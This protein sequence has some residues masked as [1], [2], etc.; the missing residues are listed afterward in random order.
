MIEAIMYFCIGFLSAALVG[1][2]IAPLIHGRAV[3]LTR[4]RLENALPQSM[5]EIIADKDLQRADFAVATRR[6]EM[7]IE[8]LKESNTSQ[9]AEIGRKDNIINRFKVD[10]QTHQV[11]TLLLR[12]EVASLREQL[13]PAAI[14]PDIEQRRTNEV[15]V[16]MRA[17]PTE[18]PGSDAACVIAS[19]A[20][21]AEP[22]PVGPITTKETVSKHEGNHSDAS[23]VPAQPPV[24]VAGDS[25][26]GPAMPE[27]VPERGIASMSRP[28]PSIHVS[29]ADHFALERTGRRTWLP[30]FGLVVVLVI[31]GSGWS[32]YRGADLPIASWKQAIIS[33][34]PKTTK[35]TPPPVEKASAPAPVEQIEDLS[36]RAPDL[37]SGVEQPSSMQ[38]DAPNKNPDLV[39]SEPPKEAL[40]SPAP[41]P[42]PKL[43]PVPETPPTTIPGWVVREVTDGT[44]VV[45]GPNGI[46]K[47]GRGDVLPGAGR[48][49]SI[50]R[51]GRRWIVATNRGLISTP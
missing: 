33:M 8:K 4:R 9:L 21:S 25:S 7:T 42:Q 41:Q 20:L 40:L 27:P 12:G 19:P 35:A 36:K 23:L 16:M 44:A 6:L 38:A 1:V 10:R 47:V 46:W 29:P 30:A 43:V 18:A 5:A 17:T 15:A 51:W 11:E 3:R 34:A 50:V 28:D 2:S 13:R 26:V 37:P 39:R 48:V 14:S 22:L 45:Q 32:Y 31:V 49:E 24:T